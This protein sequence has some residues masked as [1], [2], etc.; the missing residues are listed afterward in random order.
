MIKDNY[1]EILKHISEYAD[2][3]TITVVAVTKYQDIE[4]ANEAI[5]CGIN[6]IGENKVQQLYERNGLLLPARRHLIGHLQTNKAKHAVE[7]ADTIQSV[8]SE[9]IAVEISKQAGKI[10]KIQDAFIE[11]NIAN[12]ETKTGASVTDFKTIIETCS[13]L[14]N[15]TIT[16][17]MAIMPISCEEYYYEKMKDLYLEASSIGYK[18]TQL[19]TLSMGMSNDYV[20][21]VKHGSNM[22]RV[23]RTLFK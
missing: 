18:N 21:A 23:G 6:D 11:I 3:S 4:S 22:V 2:P 17:L 15:I 14:P 9:R 8:D 5:R 16:G 10:G 7:V 12:E 13:S 20:T 1:E 19:Q